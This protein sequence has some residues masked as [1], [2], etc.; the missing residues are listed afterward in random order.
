MFI[1]SFQKVL[2]PFFPFYIC[3]LFQTSS[4][5]QPANSKSNNTTTHPPPGFSG[6]SQPS[7]S[8]SSAGARG[9]IHPGSKV[10]NLEHLNLGTNN[11]FYS[12]ILGDRTIE[13][14]KN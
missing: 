4:D 5:P 9:L 11:D 2:N 14:I 12:G 7:T 13:L 8:S 6:N 10:F 1:G 3:I